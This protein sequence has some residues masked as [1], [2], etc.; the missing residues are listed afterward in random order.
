MSPPRENVLLVPD[1]NVLLTGSGWQGGTRSP[2]NDPEGSRPAG[3]VEKGPEETDHPAPGG[4]RTRRHR[5][6]RSAD[7]DEAEEGR[8]SLDHPRASRP[9]IEPQTEPAIA[10][11]GPADSLARGLSRL[12]SNAGQRVPGKETQAPH[13]PR[14]VAAAD[15]PSRAMAWAQ[16]EGGG[17]SP[18]AAA[19]SLARRD[20]AVGHQ[21]ARL[22]GA[23]RPKTLSDPHDR[24]RHQRVDGAIC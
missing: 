2:A 3:C 16:A 15:D 11:T 17:R 19:Q 10:R 13:R 23:S 14:S 8:R 1:R 20:G 6:A 18:M 22:A 5:A 12:R 21:R 7:A 4:R 24:R 9:A